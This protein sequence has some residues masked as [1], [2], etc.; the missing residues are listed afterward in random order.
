MYHAGGVYRAQALGESCCQPEH[1]GLGQRPAGG[2]RV[3]ERRPGDI[4][5]RQ[6]GNGSVQISIYDRGRVYAA[7][8]LGGGYFPGESGPEIGVFSQFRPDYLDRYLATSRRPAQ[9]HAA[10]AARAQPPF[11]PVRSYPSRIP[12]LQLIQLA[13]PPGARPC[14]TPGASQGIS[15]VMMI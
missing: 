3:G 15:R 7:D 5:R 11:E 10:H 6:P 4:G 9:A 1:H 13:T 8:L 2:H 12:R 14:P